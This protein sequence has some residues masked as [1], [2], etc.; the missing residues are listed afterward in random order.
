MT[1]RIVAGA[2]RALSSKTTRRGFLE[3]AAVVGSALMVSPLRYLLRP[4]PAYAVVTSPHCA[5][6]LCTSGFTT[7][8]CTIN[9][10]VNGCPPY[11]FLGGWWK[12]TNYRGKGACHKEGVRYYMDCNVTPGHSCP[13]GCHCAK[14]KCSN[15]HTCCNDFRY[16]QCTTD[17]AGITPVVCRVVKCVNP[18][19]LYANCNCTLKV[20]NATCAHEEGCL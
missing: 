16:G 14:G 4:V 7:F 11:S 1:D 18:C 8:C 12:C 9:D 10:G 19:K 3:K 15:R 13:G 5:S 6:G 2:S 20:D 17:I